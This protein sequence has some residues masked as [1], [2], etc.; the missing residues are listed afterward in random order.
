MKQVLAVL[1]VAFLAVLASCAPATI[2]PEELIVQ[3]PFD[4]AFSVVTNTINTQPYP[5]TTSGWVVTRSDQ[6]GGFVTAELEGESCAFLGLGC[7][8]Y[9]ARVSVA[10][11]ARSG[12]LTAVNI[13][14]TGER[15][16]RELAD[17]LADRLSAP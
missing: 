3:R 7:S 16:A 5:E 17:R 15:L 4:E 14:Q 10:L 8:P 9:T 6:V 11:N 13:S 2:T 12:G 1:M